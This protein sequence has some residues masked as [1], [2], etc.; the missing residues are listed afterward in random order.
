[1]EIR[2]LMALRVQLFNKADLNV[3]VCRDGKV[4]FVKLTPT[5]ALKNL[6]FLV[7]LAQ[8]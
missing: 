4:N 7:Q 1:M 5:I 3:N 6:V 2:A 8:T